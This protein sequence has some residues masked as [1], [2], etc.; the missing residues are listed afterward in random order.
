MIIKV[1]NDAGLKLFEQKIISAKKPCFAMFHMKG[2]GHCVLLRPEWEKMKKRVKS[3]VILAEIDSNYSSQVTNLIGGQV[4]G[5][6][7]LM[8]IK[9]GRRI[10]EYNGP[11]KENEMLEFVRKTFKK[12]GGFRRRRRRTK[13]RR[14]RGGSSG[15]C[16][17][18][19]CQIGGRRSRRRRSQRRR[20]RRRR[21]RRRS[22]RRRRSS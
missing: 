7:T 9:R 8:V 14:Q 2:C 17:P 22:S 11:R 12:V 18:E 15:Q 6:P 21:S 13:K 5:F 1:N 4:T 19:G 16:G 20:S 10:K 3:S